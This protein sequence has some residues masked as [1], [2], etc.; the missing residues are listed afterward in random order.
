MQQQVGEQGTGLGAPSVTARPPARTS[1]GPRI[2]NW[3]LV[4]PVA[5][6]QPADMHAST[7]VAAA[8]A[9]QR[10]DLRSA[11]AQDAALHPRDAGKAAPQTVSGTTAN[12]PAVSV[13]ATNGS[14]IDWASIAIGV[15]AS[16]L[17]M[18][19]LVALNS[20]RTHRPRVTA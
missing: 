10:Q 11:D 15:A 3:A 13:Q 5:Q 20:R 4:A 6:A 9:R 12:T 14:G 16:L 7:A 17:V 19:G 2:E 1:N 8:N 18:G